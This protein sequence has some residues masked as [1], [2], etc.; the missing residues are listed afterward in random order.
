MKKTNLPQEM[1][2]V[3]A[4]MDGVVWGQVYGPYN[5]LQDAEKALARLQAQRHQVAYQIIHSPLK[6]GS[7]TA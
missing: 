2:A 3:A 7:Y 4:V 5:R 1:Y 6:W